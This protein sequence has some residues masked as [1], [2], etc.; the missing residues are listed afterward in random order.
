MWHTSGAA[1]SQFWPRSVGPFITIAWDPSPDPSVTGYIVYVGT[2]SRKYAFAFDVGNRTSFVYPYAAGNRRHFFA[3]S[4]YSPDMGVGRSSDEV[5]GFGRLVPAAGF[6]VDLNITPF[7]SGGVSSQCVSGGAGCLAA[8]TVSAAAGRI[9]ALTSS[10]K[11]QVWFVEDKQRIFTIDVDGAVNRIERR[12]ATSRG[13]IDGLAIDPRFDE[14]RHVYVQEIGRLRDGSR[15]LT[16]SRYREVRRTLQER[17]MIISGIR[18]PPTGSAP[19]AVDGDGRIFVAVPRDSGGPRPHAGVVF[20]V[21]P[22]GKY[23]KG[24]SGAPLSWRGLSNPSG[25]VWDPQVGE[26]WLSGADRSGLAAVE[27]LPVAP[28]QNGRTTNDA[29]RFLLVPAPGGRLLRIDR[30]SARA[31]PVSLGSGDNVTAV[32]AGGLDVVFAVTDSNTASGSRIVA[33][34]MAD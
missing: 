7:G 33:I 29:R 11:G 16:I 9:S 12:S 3:V 19:F 5:S 1:Q 27:R 10:A 20:A 2:E 8:A 26:L 25:L 13:Q 4:S 15:E 24:P 23:V 18:L 21:Q 14:T 17:V 32:T 34:P 28:Q 6:P 31:E 22:D 30:H